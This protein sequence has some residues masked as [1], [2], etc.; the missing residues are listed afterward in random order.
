[1]EMLLLV[2]MDVGVCYNGK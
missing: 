1:M 2:L